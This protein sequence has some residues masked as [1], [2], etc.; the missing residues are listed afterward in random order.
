M[1]E[2]EERDDKIK[3]E[4]KTH[5]REERSNLRKGRER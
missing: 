4:R 2:R 3:R 5:G 1:E